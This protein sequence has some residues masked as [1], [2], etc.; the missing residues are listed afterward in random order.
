MLFR[1]P[2]YILFSGGHAVSWQQAGQWMGDYPKASLCPVWRM[3]SPIS[4]QR[5][6]HSLKLILYS[7]SV[8]GGG[9][10]GNCQ[11]FPLRPL[12]PCL[13]IFANNRHNCSRCNQSQTTQVWRLNPSVIQTQPLPAEP[14]LHTPSET[15]L[16]TNQ[17]RPEARVRN[18]DIGARSPS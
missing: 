9:S 10:T 11:I 18:I 7:V 8:K 17:R 3:L 12:T 1:R 4:L 13:L 5:R 2:N 6:W 15:L 16:I 14:L